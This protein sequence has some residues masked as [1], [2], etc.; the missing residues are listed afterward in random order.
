MNNDLPRKDSLAARAKSDRTIVSGKKL[1]QIACSVQE[2]SYILVKPALHGTT[3]RTSRSV[4]R[5][6]AAKAFNSSVTGNVSSMDGHV[7]RDR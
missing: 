6:I 4:S 1:V 2:T 3:K 7:T 5:G